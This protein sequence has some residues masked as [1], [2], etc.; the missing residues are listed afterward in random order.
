MKLILLPLLIAQLATAQ[1]DSL[2][3]TWN[4]QLGGNL[5]GGN[6]QQYTLNSRL[7]FTLNKGPHEWS[8]QPGGQYSLIQGATGLA[9]RERELLVNTQY[10]HRLG[11]FRWILYTE[12]EHSYLRK[13]DLRG[14]SGLGLGYKPINSKRL[15]LDGSLLLMPE[16]LL[17][18]LG[19]AFNNFAIR[20]STRIKLQYNRGGLRVSQTTLIQPAVYSIKE[21][22]K[23][24]QP[25]DN[26]NL[27]SIT[28]LDLTVTKWFLIGVSGEVIVQTYTSSINPLVKPLDYTV[29]LHIKIRG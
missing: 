26:F 16:L 1:T 6:F 28:L 22:D 4:L 29:S 27:R 19:P 24:I 25:R 15:E 12:G 20:A 23:L 17:S 14:S 18:S 2:K 8:L 10:T 21:G 9:L 7:Q 11:R 3:T 13:V 5:S